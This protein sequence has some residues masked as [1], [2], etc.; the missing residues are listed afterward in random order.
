[1]ERYRI[2]VVDDD[3]D[4]LDL[5]RMTLKEDFDVLTLSNPMELYD[6]LGLFE[7][8]LIILDIMMPK[9]TGFQLIEIL[10]KSPA[11]RSIPI[12]V[13]S[14][15]GSTREIKYGYKLGV[16]LYLTKPFQPERLSKNVKMVF[17]ENPIPLK[18]K[19]L[20]LNQVFTQ[21]QLKQS[22]KSAT[23]GSKT[24]ILE[25]SESLGLQKELP[26]SRIPRMSYIPSPPKAPTGVTP[27]KPESKPGNIP[28]KPIKEKGEEGKEQTDPD[29]SKTWLG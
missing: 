4:T 10:S 21:I 18:K 26:K 11:Y 12:I 23:E 24:G 27:K 20:T 14:A 15:K 1:M 13:L 9:I 28:Q 8:D 7:P 17:T 5:V 25:S 3:T 2:L 19:T 16:R 22:Y 29:S 6:Y